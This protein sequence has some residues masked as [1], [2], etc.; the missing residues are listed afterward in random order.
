MKTV[1]LILVLS[2]VATFAWA[3]S[4]PTNSNEDWATPPYAKA[5]KI[6]PS[7]SL[8]G[9][10]QQILGFGGLFINEAGQLAIYL[11]QPESQKEKAKE[12]LS[13]SKLI[14]EMLSRLRDQGYS[15]SIADM[16]ILNGQ[17]TLIQLDK[18]EKEINSKILPMDGV[19]TIGI[20]QSQNKVSVGVKNKTVRASLS[21]KLSN[22]NISGDAVGVYK[23]TIEF[24]VGY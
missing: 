8:M 23:I 12:V 18:W 7:D 15:V 11:T 4:T 13:N 19:Y 2:I 17:F 20:D 22:L 1:K 24:P 3:C 6:T 16:E 5:K 21:K 9:L 14:T 10:A